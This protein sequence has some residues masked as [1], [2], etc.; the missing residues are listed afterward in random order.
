MVI[1]LL[2]RTFH[3]REY[4]PAGFREF[5]NCL[6]YELNR[7][8]MLGQSYAPLMTALVEKPPYLG[9]R[10]INA[11]TFAD[12]CGGRLVIVAADR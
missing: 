11:A 2:F 7:K 3:R 4:S 5:T 12:Q 8:L 6:G 10:L 9:D 1:A